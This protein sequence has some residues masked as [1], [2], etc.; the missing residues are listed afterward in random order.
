MRN[1][2][3]NCEINLLWT[4]S[5]NCAIDSSLGGEVFAITGTNVYVLVVIFPTKEN[6]KLLQQLKSEFKH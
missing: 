3:I 6:T 2:E 4:R 1:L 5:A